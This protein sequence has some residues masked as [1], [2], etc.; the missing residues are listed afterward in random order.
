VP[1]EVEC[2]A[3]YRGD[4]TPR[5]VH[6]GSSLV[7]VAAVLERWRT[8]EHRCFR[9]RGSDGRILVLR[10]SEPEGGWVLVRRG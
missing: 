7:E 8:P 3:G 4:E 10:R 9:V 1:V 6:C 2:Y 5:R